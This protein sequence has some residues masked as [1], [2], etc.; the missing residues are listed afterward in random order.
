VNDS[1]SS[2][3][4][5]FSK[6]NDIRVDGGASANNLLMQMQANFSEKKILRPE[7]TDTT[8]YG[9]AMGALVSRGEIKISE[10]GKLWKL[11]KDF[12]PTNDKYYG[13]KRN[14]WDKTLKKV[15][16]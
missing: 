12:S 14:L 3:K 10:L 9:V 5:D 15:F 13:E 6:L 2:F 16:L 8:A 11:E 4:K 7:V 1:V